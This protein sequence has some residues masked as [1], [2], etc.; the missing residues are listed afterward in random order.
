M[1]GLIDFFVTL[2][3][4]I[5]SLIEFII[6][7]ISDLIFVI[8]LLGNL[9]L[10]IPMLFSW[11]PSAFVSLLITIFGIVVIYKILGREG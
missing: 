6:S 2:G 11:F 10:K 7:F 3:D 1:Q 9:I 8:G 4:V 5:V